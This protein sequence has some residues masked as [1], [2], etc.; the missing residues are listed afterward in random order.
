MCIKI[1]K[2]SGERP[3]PANHLNMP[4]YRIDS[5]SAV[6]VLARG[7]AQGKV[8]SSARMGHAYVDFAEESQAEVTQARLLHVGAFCL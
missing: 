8:A 1:D 7:S 4:V 6:F 2:A 5:P 3:V